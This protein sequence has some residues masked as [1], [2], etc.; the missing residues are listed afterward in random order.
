MATRH[1]VIQRAI[2]DSHVEPERTRVLNQLPPNAGSG[3]YVLYWMTRAPRATHNESLEVAKSLSRHTGLPL[4][5]LAVVDLEEAREGSLRHVLF[6]L[7]GLAELGRV[8]V[9]RHGCAPPGVH[10]RVDPS[11]SEWY[12]LSVGGV[13]MR[14]SRAVAAAAAAAPSTT[15]VGG[16]S[17][18]GHAHERSRASSPS[19][20]LRGATPE[21][22]LSSGRAAATASDALLGFTGFASRAYAIVTDRTHLRYQRARTARVAALAPCPVVEVEAALIV[23]VETASVREEL[24][25]EPFL[26]RLQNGLGERFLHELPPSAALAPPPSPAALDYLQ[27]FGFRHA[28]ARER[29]WTAEDWLAPPHR[30]HLLSILR[31]NGVDCD[32]PQIS[33]GAYR[34]G[35]ISARR[36]LSVFIARKL[37]GYACK[38]EQQNEAL[39]AEYGSLLSPYLT[40][41]H[42]SPVYV[43]V[44]VY[45]AAAERALDADRSRTRAHAA[46]DRV[47]AQLGKVSE[48][49]T[50]LAPSGGGFDSGESL[51][52]RTASGSASPPVRVVEPVAV[53]PREPQPLTLPEAVE[54]AGEQHDVRKFM[55]NMY[56]RELSYNF[57]MYNKQYDTFEGAVPPWARRALYE[58]AAKRVSRYRYSE[59]DWYNARTHDARW[60]AVQRELLTRGRNMCRDRNYWCQKMV[61]YEDDPAH[62]YALAI[63]INNHLMLDA[64]DPVGYATVAQCFG[65]WQQPLAREGGRRGEAGAR[66]DPISRTGGLAVDELS[67]GRL[68]GGGGD[69]A[70]GMPLSRLGAVP[71]IY[72]L[73]TEE[74]WRYAEELADSL[75]RTLELSPIPEHEIV[76]AY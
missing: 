59:S 60:N 2:L 23:P 70:A 69:G 34:G 47:V 37:H 21:Q 51:P 39:R 36:L 56:R 9:R 45:R 32:A 62:A 26:A 28:P 40:F 29:G 13:A 15:V 72:T 65:R 7:E 17:V 14:G 30:D 24:T 50:A 18:L 5:C 11:L 22:Q 55:E 12:A 53:R 67:A 68:G 31:Q 35:E 42:I 74:Q 58:A 46:A 61:E 19:S 64:N 8:L 25:A 73:R 76:D 71:E 33:V 10:V 1:E 57:V 41:G 27:T 54:M 6:Q 49:G 66:V 75:D 3:A 63:R 16:L 44:K 4:V 20:S 43:A 38:A 52:S 48:E